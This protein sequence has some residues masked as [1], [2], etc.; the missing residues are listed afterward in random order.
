MSVDFDELFFEE[1][2][3]R[4]ENFGRNWFSDDGCK[5][6]CAVCGKEFDLE[7]EDELTCGVCDDCISECDFDDCL[8]INGDEKEDVAINALVVSLLD[9]SDINTILINYLREANQIE[10]IDCFNYTNGDKEWFA[11]RLKEVRR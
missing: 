2:R 1:K 3:A 4:A 9:E 7:D 5:V 6:C 8:K 11:E 10:P